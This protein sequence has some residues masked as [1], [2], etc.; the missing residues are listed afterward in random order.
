M[1]KTLVEWEEWQLGAVT[2]VE[3]I[4]WLW[5]IEDLMNWPPIIGE[6]NEDGKFEFMH[7][8][9]QSICEGLHDPSCR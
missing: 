6:Y 4:A 3:M 8:W 2:A 9:H 1:T 7:A 5:A